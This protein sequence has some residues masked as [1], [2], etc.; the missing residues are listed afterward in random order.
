M[1]KTFINP[2]I[3]IIVLTQSEDI[4]TASGY[5]DSDRLGTNETP[6]W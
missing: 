1:K 5:W 6:D 3:E 4:L 2:E